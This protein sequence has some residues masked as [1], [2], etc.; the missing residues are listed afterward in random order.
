[1]SQSESSTDS[2]VT[3]VPVTFVETMS[4]A[5]DEEDEEDDDEELKTLPTEAVM[6]LQEEV[7]MMIQH[8]SKSIDYS[9][10]VLR[11]L[12]QLR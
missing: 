1:M 8:L 6:V 11:M 9:K 4:V 10:E 3:V 5:P 12:L 7:E 2:T